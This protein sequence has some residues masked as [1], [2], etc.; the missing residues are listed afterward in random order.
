VVG[1]GLLALLATAAW[2][3]PDPR[4]IGT[5]QQLGLP[6][7]TFQKMFNRPCP[8]CGMTTAWSHF[9][10][11]HLLSSVEANL[12]GTLLALVALIVGPW[13]LVSA[14]RG[15]HATRPPEDVYLALSAL[16]IAAVTLLQWA[17]RVY[18]V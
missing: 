7:C 8:S 12:G 2:L 11:G 4:G 5:H 18:A 1:G 14:W 10:R 6:P 13:L 3:E 16:A 9:V 15:R 17:L